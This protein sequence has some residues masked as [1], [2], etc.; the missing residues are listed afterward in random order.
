MVRYP[1]RARHAGGMTTL[2]HK[3]E[4]K[5]PKFCVHWSAVLSILPSVP[6]FQRYTSFFYIVEGLL[7][8]VLVKSCVS[9]W[10][11]NLMVLR[12]IDLPV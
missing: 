3:I 4:I 8:L 5:V 12:C 1:E 6:P 10:D 11:M 7:G 2:L 9:F